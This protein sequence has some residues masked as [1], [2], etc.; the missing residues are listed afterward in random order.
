M[1]VVKGGG[2]LGDPRLSTCRLACGKCAL[3]PI[4]ECDG[5]ALRI[6]PSPLSPSTVHHYQVSRR[7]RRGKRKRKA[8]RTVQVKPAVYA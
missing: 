8:A 7:D 6:A 3:E 4:Y 5:C 2:K 1:V